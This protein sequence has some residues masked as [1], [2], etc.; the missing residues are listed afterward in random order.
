MTSAHAPGPPARCGGG[1]GKGLLIQAF[2]NIP[3]LSSRPA[4]VT[5]QVFHFPFLSRSGNR[6]FLPSPPADLYARA[7]P[8]LGFIKSTR[9]QN[10]GQRCA[11]PRGRRRCGRRPHAACGS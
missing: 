7:L 1:W 11:Q 2:G 4:E 10:P 3:A 8:L 6:V 5:F 9:T